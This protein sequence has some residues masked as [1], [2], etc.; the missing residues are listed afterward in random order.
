[1]SRI[2]ELENRIIELQNDIIHLV[3]I[4]EEL[5]RYHPDNPDVIN[6]KDEHRKIKDN[7]YDC[8]LEIDEIKEQMEY[9]KNEGDMRDDGWEG[10]D[11]NTKKPNK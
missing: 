8:E 1:M 4:K 11:H 3:N 7:I 2:D 6:V 9:V 10:F 5:W